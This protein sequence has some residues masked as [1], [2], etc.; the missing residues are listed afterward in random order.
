MVSK[1]TS[2]PPNSAAPAQQPEEKQKKPSRAAAKP[3]GR[4]VT[5]RKKRPADE[6]PPAEAAVQ[7]AQVVSDEDIRIRAYFLSLEYRGGDRQDVDFWL[8]AEREMRPAKTPRE[9]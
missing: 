1:R 5:R 7:P 6:A 9:P 8:L 4:V 3:G 2:R